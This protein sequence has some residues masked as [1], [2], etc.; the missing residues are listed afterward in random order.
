MPDFD[1]APADYQ[2]YHILSGQPGTS[3]FAERFVDGRLI[4]AGGAGTAVESKSWARIKAS[5]AE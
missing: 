4:G 5:F 2:A 1:T 3:A